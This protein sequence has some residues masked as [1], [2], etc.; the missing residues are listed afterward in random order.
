ML[1]LTK[2]CHGV[3]V[4]CLLFSSVS[5][6]AELSNNPDCFIPL[7]ECS[8]STYPQDYTVT[9]V[10]WLP[11]GRTQCP[12]AHHTSYQKLKKM[13][14]ASCRARTNM[15]LTRCSK[16]SAKSRRE[17][18]WLHFPYLWDTALEHQDLR[19][20]GAHYIL[21]CKLVWLHSNTCVKHFFFF[22]PLS[23]WT[24]LL[25]SKYANALFS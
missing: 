23:G 8:R 24:S 1:I 15:T 9:E 21:L 16:K 14:I 13:N 5:F 2:V 7:Q 22:L 17:L 12:A 4:W 6:S 19:N 3:R 25:S 10:V 18:A 20:L 11:S